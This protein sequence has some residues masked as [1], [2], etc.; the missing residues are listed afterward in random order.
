MSSREA[1]DTVGEAESRARRSCATFSAY[2][3]IGKWSGRDVGT[4]SSQSSEKDV[5]PA[6]KCHR[7]EKSTSSDDR[8]GACT[9]A[10]RERLQPDCLVVLLR[11][12]FRR[13][14]KAP[15]VGCSSL[16]QELRVME[17]VGSTLVLSA[18]SGSMPRRLQVLG[19]LCF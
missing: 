17:W 4:G 12:L 14:G 5:R 3:G 16:I 13:G 15:E 18:D 7:G 9:C 10:A 11:E 19:I 6:C 2:S 8:P 1:G